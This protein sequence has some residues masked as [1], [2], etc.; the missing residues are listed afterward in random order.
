[1]ASDRDVEEFTGAV[2]ALVEVIRRGQSR[3]FNTEQVAV[4]QL[5]AAGDP[6]PP[7]EIAAALGVPRSSIT[8]RIQELQ[9]TGKVEIR[10]SASDGR[11]YRVRLTPAGRAE[12]DALAAKGRDLFAAWISGW[13]SEEISTFTAL[14]RRL[15]GLPHPAPNRDRHG[16]WWKASG[17]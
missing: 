15:T 10:P 11:S 13:T 4:M 3:A 12:L 14:A 16:A 9:R 17:T 7:S 2:M 5:L 1:V 8:R 6:L